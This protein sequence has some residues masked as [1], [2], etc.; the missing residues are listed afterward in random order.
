MRQCVL[1]QPTK[2]G[3]RVVTTW[4]DTRHAKVGVRIRLKNDELPGWW[5]VGI[6]GS[7]ERTPQQINRGWD[8]N[9]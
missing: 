4:I 3:H 9:V 5:D 8:N 2:D 7:V 1:T 6:V